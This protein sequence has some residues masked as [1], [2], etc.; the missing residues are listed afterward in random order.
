MKKIILQILRIILI[1]LFSYTA[2]HKLIDLDFFRQT[3]MKSTL[4]E[5]YQIDFLLYFV[6]I[7]EL[8]TIF[9]LIAEKYIFG[10]YMSLLLMLTFTIYLI[11]MNN[12]SF[13][14]GCSCGGIFNE[15]SYFEHIAA[16]I[17]FILISLIGIFLYTDKSNK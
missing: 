6:P 16:N 10:L 4:I 14:K 15:L 8:L 11:V 2:Y 5:E 9:L 7:I 13:Y 3:L 1:I 17:S 12:F